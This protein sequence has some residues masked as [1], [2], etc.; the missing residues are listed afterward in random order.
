MTFQDFA[1]EAR[2]LAD[3]NASDIGDPGGMAKRRGSR[4]C[5]HF[6]FADGEERRVSGAFPASRQRALGRVGRSLP[7]AARTRQLLNETGR[8]TQ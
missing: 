1:T 6:N 7:D 8:N 5:Q 4:G 3:D 2:T